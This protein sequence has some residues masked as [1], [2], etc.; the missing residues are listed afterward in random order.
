[1]DLVELMHSEN[2]HVQQLDQMVKD[3]L[4]EEKMLSLRLLEVEKEEKLSFHQQ[5]ADKVASFGGSWKFILSFLGF[6]TLWI[7]FNVIWVA[8]K[9]FD[10]YPFI[11]L[12]LILSCV[13][14]LQAPIIMMSQNRKE[15]KDRLR[16]RS[17]YMINLKAELEVRGLHRKVDLLMA[18]EMKMLFQFQQKQLELLIKIQAQLE[19]NAQVAQK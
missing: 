18:E 3:S 1:M 5:I 11:L 4:D 12:N 17:D 10:P 9:G 16:S 13:A 7:G 6:M 19:N 8:N 14:A 15:D 2:L